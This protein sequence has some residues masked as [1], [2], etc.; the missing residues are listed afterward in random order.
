MRLIDADALMIAVEK[1]FEGVCVYDVPPS[2]AVSDFERIVDNMP[3][4][5]GLPSFDLRVNAVFD[6]VTSGRDIRFRETDE[7]C[8]RCQ[9]DLE[10]YY[11]ENRTYIVRCKCCNIVTL[12]SATDPDEAA[13][14]VGLH[15]KPVRHGRWIEVD[16]ITWRGADDHPI[17][18]TVEEKCSN[19]G[20]YVERYET[21]QQENYCPTCGVKMDLKEE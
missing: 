16:R 3:T 10:V 11:C 4:I 14:K 18:I 6:R 21:V 2:E 12:V 17:D 8:P 20:R 1:E 7:M 9:R 19:C 13:A 5:A 15:V